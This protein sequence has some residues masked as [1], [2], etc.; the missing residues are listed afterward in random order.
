M[1]R[2]RLALAGLV[3]PLFAG[4]GGTLDWTTFVSY[5]VKNN[6]L[7]PSAVDP[8]EA[9]ASFIAA[10]LHYARIDL[11]SFFFR[12]VGG[13]RGQ[14]LI[15]GLE[16]SGVVPGR[17]L[18]TVFDLSK[19]GHDKGLVRYQ[20]LG[21][22]EPFLYKGDDVVVTVHIQTVVPRETKDLAAQLEGAADFLKRLDPVRAV[23]RSFIGTTL[24]AST[25]SPLRRAERRWRYTFTFRGGDRIYRDKSE[26]LFGAGRFVLLA[27][28]PT[29]EASR[30]ELPK[31]ASE[32][33]AQLKLQDG[34]LVHA[35]TDEEYTA[36]PH[37]VLN[38]S[39]YRRYPKPDTAFR[40]ASAELRSLVE[41]GNASLVRGTIPNLRILLNQDPHLS[42][43]EKNLERARLDAVSAEVAANEA[44]RSSIPAEELRAVK[45]WI[46]HLLLIGRECNVILEP[47]ER[48]DLLFQLRSLGQRAKEI[49][50]AM[51]QTGAIAEK[52]AADIK[53]LREHWTRD[54]EEIFLAPRVTRTIE[55]EVLPA[56][57]RVSAPARDFDAKAQS[58]KDAKKETSSLDVSAPLRQIP[59]PA[60]PPKPF[61]K[62]WWFWTATGGGVA[63]LT[64]IL[65]LVLSPK[66]ATPIALPEG[67]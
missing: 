43:R 34:R 8:A 26:L 46:D 51:G 47:F 38:I 25:F 31:K 54:N 61:Y 22:I 60:S 1:S 4:C 56:P 66:A 59:A 62:T 49:E 18:K 23:E 3:V 45:N 5:R 28:P 58:H 44:R 12:D 16:V 11:E 67:F 32:F 35:K 64:T 20:S 14:P 42:T 55:P 48:E 50:L 40:R 10:E 52:V 9:S 21:A 15:V 24:F 53:G 7:A 33:Q 65:V 39:R 30:A 6:R 19:E 57:A 17:T 37:L 13:F 2:S 29:G 63:A 27:L 41:A 36:T